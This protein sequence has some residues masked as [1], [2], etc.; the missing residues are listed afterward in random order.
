[1][2]IDALVEQGKAALARQDYDQAR[3]LFRRALSQSPFRG[4]IKELLALALDE[5]PY[6]ADSG[7]TGRTKVI[8]AV[9]VTPPRRKTLLLGVKTRKS[10]K[11][12]LRLVKPVLIGLG[13][14]ALATIG[15]SA[16]HMNRLQAVPESKP[17][18]SPEI[19]EM[20]KRAQRYSASGRY[21]EA[22]FELDKARKRSQNPQ[23]IN[24]AEA[25]VHYLHANV[26]AGHKDYDQAIRVLDRALVLEPGEAKYLAEKGW[27]QHLAAR[28]ISISDADKA[29]DFE[30]E[31]CETLEKALE[32][33]PDNVLALHT[34]GRAYSALDQKE[35][36][37]VHYQHLIR[38][39]PDSL[40]AQAARRELDQWGMAPE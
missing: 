39:Q 1:M 4:D 8:D 17:V 18:T 16:F 26:L 15:F 6:A 9:P 33:D 30:R 23:M 34:L 19:L 35:K 12:T 21:E 38:I 32:M 3:R 11:H 25:E 7:G 5:R 36:A 37:A 20:M 22:V 31:A 10:Q 13:L 2:Q 29:K 27:N 24:E 28:N 40:Q 14:I